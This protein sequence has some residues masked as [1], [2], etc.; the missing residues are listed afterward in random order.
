MPRLA[1]LDGVAL[2]IYA[3]AALVMVAT[4]IAEAIAGGRP[5]RSADGGDLRGRAGLA[6]EHAVAARDGDT[7][8]P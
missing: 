4:L 5:R 8:E 3:L 6:V 2:P 7:G 1:V